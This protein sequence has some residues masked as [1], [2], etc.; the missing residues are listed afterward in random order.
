MHTII[1]YRL[2][3]SGSLSGSARQRSAAGL[4][5]GPVLLR[6]GVLS[7]PVKTVP[8]RHCPLTQTGSEK[9]VL[10]PP[11]DLR[12][13]SALP[14]D[15]IIRTVLGNAV[16]SYSGLTLIGDAYTVNIPYRKRIL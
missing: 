8:V 7:V 4:R 14:Y 3:L 5:Y 11:A 13:P 6:T 10:V 1:L 9:Q 16:K 12:C 2:I 15:G